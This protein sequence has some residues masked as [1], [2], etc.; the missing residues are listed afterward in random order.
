MSS[1]GSTGQIRARYVL[2]TTG[3]EASCAAPL[4]LPSP[5]A[6]LACLGLLGRVLRT[7]LL[8]AAVPASSS[9]AMRER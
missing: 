7:E 5:L 2:S 4:T 3:V 1:T 6:L 8:I 9:L